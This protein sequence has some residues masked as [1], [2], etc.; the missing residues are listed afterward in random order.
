MKTIIGVL[1]LLALSASAAMAENV[2][3]EEIVAFTEGAFVSTLDAF[4]GSIYIVNTTINLNTTRLQK[5]LYSSR[6]IGTYISQVADVADAVF[7]QYPGRVN[8]ADI[9]VHRPNGELL[10]RAFIAAPGY[11][12][13]V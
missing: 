11:Y 5:Y 8:F 13:P 6:D 3:D 2:T 12:L 7:A 4:N 1:L 9:A 10:G